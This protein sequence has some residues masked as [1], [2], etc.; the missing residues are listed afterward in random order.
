M[1]DHDVRSP[2]N[3]TFADEIA[4]GRGWTFAKFDATMNTLRSKMHS[5]SQPGVLQGTAAEDHS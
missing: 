4:T 1:I 5:M 3:W 2:L